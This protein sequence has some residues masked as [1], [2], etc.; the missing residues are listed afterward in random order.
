MKLYNK[1]PIEYW[2]EIAYEVQKLN[3]E[4]NTVSNFTDNLN[5]LQKI[6]LD[7]KNLNLST[8]ALDIKPESIKRTGLATLLEAIYNI[9]RPMNYKKAALYEQIQILNELGVEYISFNPLIFEKLNIKNAISIKRTK[10]KSCLV[11]K[12]CYTDGIFE[13]KNNLKTSSKINYDYDMINI[14]NTDYIIL[15]TVNYS[16]KITPMQTEAIIKGFNGKYP[17]KEELLTNLTPTIH[18]IPKNI[19]IFE[20][21]TLQE[22]FCYFKSSELECSKNLTKNKNGEY[23]YK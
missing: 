6:L 22:Q 4:E 13:I 1:V 21:I 8:L 5:K 15:S 2:K 16:G 18:I 12:R 3:I 20:P 17:K 23:Y 10:D 19:R 9:K 11:A 14:V 7:S